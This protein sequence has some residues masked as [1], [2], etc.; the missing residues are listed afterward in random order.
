M[1]EA[2]VRF[3]KNLEILQENYTVTFYLHD[4]VYL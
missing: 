2:Y 1:T 3:V 4:A